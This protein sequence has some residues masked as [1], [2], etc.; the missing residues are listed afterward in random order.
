MI[1]IARIDERLI[2]GQVAYAW[3]V[4]YKSEAI[5]VIDNEVAEDKFQVSL[6]QMAC[7]AGVKCMVCNEEKGAE[8]L[9]KYEKRKIFVVVKHPSALL[10]LCRKGI[11]LKEINVGGLYFKEGRRQISKTVYVD[12]EMEE[13]FQRLSELGVK[14]ENRTTPTDSKEDLMKLM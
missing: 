12:P 3:S 13:I 4:A 11:E 8:L 9:K 10:S 7:P 1:T 6:L 2:H 14:L 5:M